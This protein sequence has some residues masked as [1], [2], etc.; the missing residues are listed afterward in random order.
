MDN[1]GVEVDWL[2]LGQNLPLCP[3]LVFYNIHER[4]KSQFATCT[5]PEICQEKMH[6]FWG[7]QHSQA[8]KFQHLNSP[9]RFHASWYVL[10]VWSFTIGY[11]FFLQLVSVL[12]ECCLQDTVADTSEILFRLDNVLPT[13]VVW[14]LYQKHRWNGF[15]DKECEKGLSCVKVGLI[16]VALVTNRRWAL[17]KLET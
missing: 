12:Q 13:T 4:R 7:W 5:W 16:S 17:T 14:A 9:T 1:C 2:K 8:H 15:P 3:R 10:K 6:T 11:I